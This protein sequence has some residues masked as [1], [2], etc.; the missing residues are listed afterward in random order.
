M[1]TRFSDCGGLIEAGPSV[2]DVERRVHSTEETTEE[3]ASR[4]V[5][6]VFSVGLQPNPLYGSTNIALAL[7][8]AGKVS[9]EIFDVQGRR[10]RTLVDEMRQA[11][12]HDIVWNGRDAARSVVGS[13]VYFCRIR[14]DG[15]SAAMEKMIKL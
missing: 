10:V 2:A 4:P 5:P 11:G 3:A 1:N 14:I 15:Q 8:A 6:E 12:F 13:G 9:V 7:P